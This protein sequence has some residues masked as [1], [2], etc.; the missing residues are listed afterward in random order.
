MSRGLTALCLA[1][2]SMLL[3][4]CDESDV[5]APGPDAQTVAE[6]DSSADAGN[7]VRPIQTGATVAIDDGV[8]V[9]GIDGSNRRFFNIPFAKPP[10]GNLR[11]RAPERNEPWAE[12]RDATAPG[13]QCP[14]AMSSVSV[15]SDTEDCLQ[16]NVWAPEPVSQELRPVMVWFHGGANRYGSA[17]QNVSPTLPVLS[18]GGSRLAE[19]GVVVVT[20]NYRSVRSASSLTLRSPRRA[21]RSAIK[22]CS[23]SAWRCSG[24]TSP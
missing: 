13:N 16:L 20:A 18:Y 21:A 10:V 6:A 4:G 1:V 12:P 5:S 11:W 17:V 9:G 3:A 15:P 24:C 7:A 19:H 14:Q 8:L 2:G 22:A 23:I